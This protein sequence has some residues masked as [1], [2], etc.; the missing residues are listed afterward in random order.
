MD[1]KGDANVEVEDVRRYLFVL[2]STIARS[3]GHF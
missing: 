3:D 2:V 1:F